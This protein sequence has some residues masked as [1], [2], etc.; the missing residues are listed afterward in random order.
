[1]LKRSVWKS[2][3]VISI[4][5]KEDLFT[6]AQMRENSLMEFFDISRPSDQWNGVDLNHVSALFCI[7]VADG[8]IKSLFESAPPDVI[9]N[10]RPV[11]KR[12]LS[13][14]VKEQGRYGVDLIELD[15]RY[16]SVEARVVKHDLDPVADRQLIL[17]HELTGMVG[18]P[19]KLHKRLLR[20]YETGQDVDDAK[21]F[22]FPSLYS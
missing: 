13:F 10:Q 19:M 21:A 17:N 1:M 12:M 18:D 2:G 22:I 6:L 14:T 7:Y 9:S 5:L 20:Y 4:K 8:R 11:A 16:S 15:D 3:K